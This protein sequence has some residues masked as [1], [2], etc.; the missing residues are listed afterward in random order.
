MSI[1]LPHR[2]SFVIVR[3]SRDFYVGMLRMMCNVQKSG[4]QKNSG[5]CVRVCAKGR[6]NESLV[7]RKRIELSGWNLVCYRS[8]YYSFIAM[9]FIESG[10]VLNIN[11]YNFF[12]SKMEIDVNM[13]ICANFQLLYYNFNY[14]CRYGQGRL[15]LH[16]GRI[17]ELVKNLWHFF[18]NFRL[19]SAAAITRLS[20]KI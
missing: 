14:E 19:N 3:K 10:C 2:R 5:V 18:H 12:F 15:V 17:N 20:W 13:L 9:N 8:W 7:I 4:L 6:R 16:L 11:I 1:L